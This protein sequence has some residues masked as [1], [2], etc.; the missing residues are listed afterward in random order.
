MDGSLERRAAAGDTAAQ[1]ALARQHEDAARHDL[2]RGWYARAAKAGD[3]AALRLLAINLLTAEPLAVPDGIGMIRDAAA[4]GDAE[5]AHLCA[6]LA[7]Q[8]QA[9]P[10]NWSIALDYL[11]RAATLGSAAAREQL[12][13]L[14]DGGKVDVARWL[15][16]VPARPVSEAPRIAVLEG[17]ASPAECDWLIARARPRLTAAE[18]YDP[19]SGGG[20][21]AEDIRSNS[22]ASFNI[23]QSDL[24]LVLLRT[25]IARATALDAGDMEP[26]MVLHYAVGQQFAPHFDFIDPES[27]ALRPGIARHGQRVATFLLYLNDDFAGGETDFPDLGWRHKGR[28]GDALLFWNALPDNQPDRTTR[29]AGVAPTHG[30]KWLLSQWLRRR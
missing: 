11:A 10:S 12:A 27:P 7:A 25:R 4:R 17:F 16:P 23:A 22:A 2:A 19:G 28:K 9:L 26:A 15:A 13:L 20:R 8:D 18:V 3:I 24:V 14:G 30:E 21:R 1:I 5:A 29:H 6:V